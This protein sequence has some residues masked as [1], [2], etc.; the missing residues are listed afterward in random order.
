MSSVTIVIENLENAAWVRR[1]G[2]STLTFQFPQLEE[3]AF[4]DGAEVF[5][6]NRRIMNEILTAVFMTNRKNLT[7]QQLCVALNW[8]FE[9]NSE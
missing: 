7:F 2:K 8:G 9:I 4:F 1:F 6:V 5:K 3:N